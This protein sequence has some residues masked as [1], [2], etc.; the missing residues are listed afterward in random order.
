MHPRVHHALVARGI[1]S[2]VDTSR[3]WPDWRAARRTAILGAARAHERAAHAHDRRAAQ[4][5]R[6]GLDASA[7]RA[8]ASRDRAAAVTDRQHAARF[9]TDE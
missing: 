4:L 8:A 5:E 7:E 1:P 3:W 6:A 9:G 2:S